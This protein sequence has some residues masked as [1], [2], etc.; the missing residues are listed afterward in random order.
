MITKPDMLYEYK[1]FLNDLE[2][3]FEDAENNIAVNFELIRLWGALI[4]HESTVE[5]IKLYKSML[6]GLVSQL[7]EKQVD[8]FLRTFNEQRWLNSFE[9]AQLGKASQN[10]LISM[11]WYLDTYNSGLLLKQTHIM[12]K[13]QINL[14]KNSIELVESDFDKWVLEMVEAKKRCERLAIN[15]SYLF[16]SVFPTIMAIAGM[17]TKINEYNPGIFLLVNSKMVPFM[18]NEIDEEV[19]KDLIKISAKE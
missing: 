19:R 1:R 6:Y 7:T 11:I 5:R 12:F 9:Y 10:V 17:T 16:K 8:E 18:L 13:K 3:F 15:N 4:R 2:Q 14:N